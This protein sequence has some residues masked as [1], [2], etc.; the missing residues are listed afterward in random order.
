MRTIEENVY[1][2]TELNETAKEKV[3][4]WS[5]TLKDSYIFTDMCKDE[6]FCLFGK[7]DLEVYYSLN[8]SQGDCF[9]IVGSIDIEQ[10]FTAL[11]NKE[12]IKVLNDFENLFTEKEIRTLQHYSQYNGSIEISENGRYSEKIDFANEWIDTLEYYE[13]R[14]INTN[15]IY[16]LEEVLRDL[17]STLCS[18]F[19]K[20]GY[21]YFYTFDPYDVE[22][23]EFY[24]NGEVY[25]C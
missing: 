14:D 15:V 8:Y 25:Y 1:S 18:E 9:D 10:V 12:Q 19:M 6:L 20:Q 11:K 23:Y 3:Q 21:D 2:Y 5:L 24:E 4:N 16:K 7:N 22:D 13:Y 17:F